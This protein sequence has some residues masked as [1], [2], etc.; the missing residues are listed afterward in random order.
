MMHRCDTGKGATAVTPNQLTFKGISRISLSD[1]E[2]L[3][4][5]AA[6]GLG[7]MAKGKCAAPITQMTAQ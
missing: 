4:H 5:G 6:K 3:L 1:L 2:S 7:L